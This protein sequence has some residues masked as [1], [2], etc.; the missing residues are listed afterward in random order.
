VSVR[1]KSR[2]SATA[3]LFFF[4]FF[5]LFLLSRPFFFFF[6]LPHPVNRRFPTWPSP[7][8]LGLDWW[9]GEPEGS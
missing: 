1:K 8:N 6:F 3:R 5:F 4:F 7:Q 2:L 9:V